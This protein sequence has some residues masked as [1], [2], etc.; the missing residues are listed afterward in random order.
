MT[1]R[2]HHHFLVQS[3]L[4][5]A[6]SVKIKKRFAVSQWEAALADEMVNN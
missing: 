2:H 4:R 5:A 1:G 3:K 6:Y